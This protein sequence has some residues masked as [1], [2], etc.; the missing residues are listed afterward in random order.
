LIQ[1]ECGEDRSRLHPILGALGTEATVTP[2]EESLD[3][4]DKLEELERRH[5]ALQYI[6]GWYSPSELT[7]MERA[8]GPLNNRHVVVDRINNQFATK[9]L[10][11]FLHPDKAEARQSFRCIV[12]NT[13]D[14]EMVTLVNDEQFDEIHTGLSEYMGTVEEEVSANVD[15]NL[16][17]IA[18]A[19]RMQF[20][21]KKR[22][23]LEHMRR[24]GMSIAI[25]PNAA[26]IILEKYALAGAG[27]LPLSEYVKNERILLVSGFPDYSK[28]SHAEHDLMDHLWTFD[29]IERA[30][31]LDRYSY[32]FDSIGNPEATDI[33]RREGEIVSSIAFGVRYY[34]TMP[35]AFGPRMRSSQIEEHLDKLFV[36]GGLEDRHFEAFR[37]LKSLRR[38]SIEW[39]SLGF[40]FSNYITE[41]DEQRRKWGRIKQR[42]PRTKELLGELDPLSPDFLCFFID[43]H[44][45]LMS[46]KNKHRDDLLRFHIIFEEFLTSFAKGEIEAGAPKVFKLST[47]REV[48]FTKTTLPPSRI[49]WMRNNL[50]FTA[51][52][53]TIL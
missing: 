23:S 21:V 50:G 5:L 4:R 40:S 52:R 42:D 7:P 22:R 6:Q 20:S 17:N 3:A 29:V 48:D 35:S 43:T 38:G 16:E 15:E 2:T 13:V 46:P 41:L 30:G 32:M 26:G 45:E 10:P 25:D 39:Q 34:H 47:L 53:D 9:I 27:I 18:L 37:Y 12:P 33:F 36:E 11:V 14:E 19:D 28:V 44:K 24:N 51:T 49:Q 31:L 1:P 8:L